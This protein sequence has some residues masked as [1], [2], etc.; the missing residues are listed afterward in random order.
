MTLR[1][2]GDAL[3][4]RNPRVSVQEQIERADLSGGTSDTAGVHR[5]WKPAVISYSCEVPMDEAATVLAA[6]RRAW[7][8]TDSG[9]APYVWIVTHPLLEALGIDRAIFADFF[10]VAPDGRKRLYNVTMNLL[11]VGSIPGRSGERA[12]APNESV[13]DPSAA[14]TPAGAGGTVEKWLAYFD[15]KAGE[16][17]EKFTTKP[18]PP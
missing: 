14:L 6:L 3:P 4:G 7:H 17:I 10:K 1:L 5:G 12:P 9:G 2:D 18:P 11:E 8:T 16:L 15:T 13:D